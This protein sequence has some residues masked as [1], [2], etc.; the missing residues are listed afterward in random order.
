MSYYIYKH[1]NKINGKVYIGQTCRDPKKRYGSNG[2]QYVECPYFYNAIKK[3]GWNNFDHEVL[4]S[5]LSKEEANEKEIEM[6]RFYDSQ[7]PEKGYNLRAG[8]DGFDSESSKALWKNPE[9]AKR[10]TEANIEKWKDVDYKADITN[11][12]IEAWKDPVKRKRRSEAAKARWANKE[13]RDKAHQ[14]TKEACRSSVRCI[15]TGEVFMS[16]VDACNKYNI[17]HSNLIRSIRKGYRSGGVHC[18]RYENVS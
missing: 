9:Y 5:D 3:Y 16:I 11:R 4:Y 15:E 7:N 1:T 14:A 17:H 2:C 18:E 13:F 8:G 12:M 10:I 6:I